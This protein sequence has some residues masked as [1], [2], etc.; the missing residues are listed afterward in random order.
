MAQK[1]WQILVSTW[2]FIALSL[3]IA[4]GQNFNLQRKLIASDR[5]TQDFLGESA[6]ISSNFAVVGAPKEDEDAVGDNT[7]YDA[8]AAY[9][10][11]RNAQGTWQQ[12][13]KIVA[14]DRQEY[15]YFGA[16]VCISGSYIAIGAAAQDYD[17]TGGGNMY[18]DAGAVYIFERNTN[19]VW[20]QVQKIVPSDRGLGD[21]FGNA[22]SIS[23]TTLLIGASRHSDSVSNVYTEGGGAAYIYERNAQGRWVQQQRLIA[24]DRSA[25]DYFGTSVSISGSLA[26]IGAP[27]DDYDAANANYR[28][29]AGAV[30]VFE[31]NATTWV[32]TNKIVASDRTSDTYFGNSVGISGNY[33]VVGA[34]RR[35][36]SATQVIAG[37]AYFYEKNTSGWAF[38]NMVLASDREAGDLFGSSVSISGSTAVIG[39][40][41]EDN[42][43]TGAS[44]LP[45]AGSAYIILRG[46]NGVWSQSQKIVGS[47]RARSEYFG[48]NVCISG[49]DI[50]VGSPNDAGDINGANLVSEAGSAIVFTRIPM[51]CTAVSITSQPTN[52]SICEGDTARLSIR[53]G[54]TNPNIQW[55]SSANGTSGWTTVAGLIDTDIRIV[56]STTVYYRAVI[57]NTCSGGI[58][59][60]AQ[61]AVTL[62][63]SVRVSGDTAVC[64]GARAVLRAAGAARYVWNVGVTTDSIV[65]T[66]SASGTYNYFVTGTTGVC[67]SSASARIN[68]KVVPSLVFRGDTAICVGTNTVLKVLGATTYVWSNGLRS[69][70]ILVGSSTAGYLNFSVTGTTNG[71][72]ASASYRLSVRALPTVTFNM[73]IS[74][75]L[76]CQNKSPFVLSGGSPTGGT[77]SGTNVANNIFSPSNLIIG[78]HRI[79]YRYADVIGCASTAYDSLEVRLCNP[80]QDVEAQRAFAIYPNPA[81]DIINI[82]AVA[83]FSE[84][85][86]IQVLNVLGQSVFS[87]KNIIFDKG[88]IFSVP[89]NTWQEGTYI[90][91][92]S[93]KN[94]FFTQKI[95]VLK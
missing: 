23:G 91:L 13:Q 74:Q 64:V 12:V 49:D 9:I 3:C 2:V 55:E 86:D 50:I 92:F 89:I 48:E 18:E 33:A 32:Q 36:A 38:A 14:S 17:A 93:N 54:G 43:A 79:A 28:Y 68:S 75:K 46:S 73:P 35:N 78:K 34:P 26:V 21:N 57:S 52:V 67:S 59:N 15:D 5:A 81:S 40:G 27:N 51:V 47:D 88:Q 94:R 61:I 95:N 84:K 39:A 22:L 76:N 19:N 69:D 63:P 16:A 7:V 87:E 24:A 4:Q 6:S 65:V 53:V 90:I 1:N 37:A 71:C 20:V 10:Y 82:V 60:V 80:T 62:R 8:G 25:T 29:N 72:S 41:W 42:D 77:Y 44:A 30:Y 58:S 83:D 31:K 11:F 66:P 45:E 85:I 56:T 70:S